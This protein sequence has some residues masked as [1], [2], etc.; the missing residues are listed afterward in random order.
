MNTILR[1]RFAVYHVGFIK[2]W[3]RIS[4]LQLL[5]L[6]LVALSLPIHASVYYVDIATGSDSNSGTS[7]TSPWAH[8]PGTVGGGP[9]RQL[10]PGDTV[11][12][13]GG[14]VNNCCVNVDDS[15]YHGAAAFDSVLIQ[16]G[17]LANPAWGTGRAVFD[18]Q[19]TR[20][21]GFGVGAGSGNSIQG[22]TID[23]FEVRNIA[24]STSSGAPGN[25]GSCCISIQPPPSGSVPINYVT[26]R[27]CYLH[28]A[29]RSVDDTG[30]GM[31]IGS[32]GNLLIY[33]NIVGPNIGTK[34]IELSGIGGVISNNFVTYTGDHCIAITRAT[35]F[36]VCNNVIR[37]DGPQVH[38]PTFFISCGA[39]TFNDVWNNVGFDAQS[40][41]SANMWSSAIGQYNGSHNNNFYNN[42]FGRLGSNGG[43][44]GSAINFGDGG[45]AGVTYEAAIN[46]L[47]LSTTNVFGNSFMLRLPGSGSPSTPLTLNYNCW[48]NGTPNQ[49]VCGWNNG[50]YGYSTIAGF[51][52]SGVTFA[53]NVNVNPVVAGGAW[54]NGL[55][56]NGHPNSACFALTAGSPTVVTSTGNSLTGDSTHGYDHSPGKFSVDIL[57]NPRTSWSMGAY[58]YSSTSVSSPV[59][60]VTPSTQNFGTIP[61]GTSSNLNFTVKNVGGSTLTGTASVPLPFKLIAGGTYSLNA[62][63]SQ[64]VTVSYAPLSSEVDS[65]SVTFTGGGGA[66]ASV[67]GTAVPPAPTGLHVV[68]SP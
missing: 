25:P 59:A 22:I 57:G 42:T 27:R 48:W 8:L 46:N 56:A 18:E 28:D 67:S 35:N 36:D 52:Q 51:S 66:T 5:L 30:H 21:Y 64:T 4:Q 23:G 7:A 44:S 31:E 50:S 38:S 13:K 17:H 61:V 33:Y 26:I 41:D 45:T 32:S 37:Q 47:V 14:S 40:A 58:E 55:D 10:Q 43:G 12:V 60:S 49:A 63:Q 16:S 15:R 2:G 20:F 3:L 62:G 54:P 34:G 24:A 6:T 39:S 65:Q 11:L 29:I 68:S 1:N 9:A 53:G 19:N